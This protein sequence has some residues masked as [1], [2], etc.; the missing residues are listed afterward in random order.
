M[1]I[2]RDAHL[3]YHYGDDRHWNTPDFGEYTEHNVAEARA[4][5]EALSTD[6]ARRRALAEFCVAHGED[7]CFRPS[8]A[9][10]CCAF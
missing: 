1:L 9:S 6:S 10:G 8:I 7:P 4:V 5:L 2:L 3:T